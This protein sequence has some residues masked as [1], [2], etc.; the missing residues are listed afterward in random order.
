[1]L[2]LAEALDLIGVAWGG[3]AEVLHQV[4]RV[5]RQ[6]ERAA[7]EREYYEVLIFDLKAVIVE[8]W[9]VRMDER[10]RPLG[11]Q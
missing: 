11:L 5:S 8:H 6:P 1:M 10:G 3:E 2:R 9:H 4:A 7:A